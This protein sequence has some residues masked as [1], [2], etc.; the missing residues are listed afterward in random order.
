MA[1][2]IRE[3]LVSRRLRPGALKPRRNAH[4]APQSCASHCGTDPFL[5]A[6]FS[7][8]TRVIPDVAVFPVPRRWRKCADARR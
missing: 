4:M 1:Q 8:Y 6:A 3:D 5:G 2:E 7:A